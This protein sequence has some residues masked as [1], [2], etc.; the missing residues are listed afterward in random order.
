MSATCVGCGS[1]ARWTV[2][3]FG[4]NSFVDSPVCY[5]CTTMAGAAEGVALESLQNTETQQVFV[6]GET[7]SEL[8]NLVPFNFQE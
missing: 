3:T 8:A 2:K 1:S 7:V 4:L 6:A 5:E